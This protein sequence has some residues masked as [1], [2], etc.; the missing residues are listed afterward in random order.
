MTISQPEGWPDGQVNIQSQSTLLATHTAA[1]GIESFHL[2]TM[3]PNAIGLIIYFKPVGTT[4]S[5]I[6]FVQGVNSNADYANFINL[7]INSAPAYIP[8]LANADPILNI[9]ITATAGD[10]FKFYQ[11]FQTLGMLPFYGS[12]NN[13]TP[14]GAALTSVLV[15]NAS[16]VAIPA[17]GDGY[18]DAWVTPVPQQGLSGQYPHV[19]L[20]QVASGNVVANATLVAS[21]GSLLRLRLYEV[22]LQAAPGCSADSQAGIVQIGVREFTNTVG[23]G[24]SDKASF[25]P[26]GLPLA[27]NTGVSLQIFTGTTPIF[28]GRVTYTVETV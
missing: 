11:A 22:A 23:A 6:G 7:G 21:P 24:M 16:G 27:T 26:F 8:I 25:F 20:Q 19:E 15:P 17:R 3:L 4:P 9:Q 10:V 1:G 2:P 28:S 13:G 5:L 12:L 14:A 18:G